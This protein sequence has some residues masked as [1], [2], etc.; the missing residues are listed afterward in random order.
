MRNLFTSLKLEGIIIFVSKKHWKVT[1][2]K[3]REIFSSKPFF[4]YFDSERGYQIK[5]FSE[6]ISDFEIST[7]KNFIGTLPKEIQLAELDPLFKN[8]NPGAV[9]RINAVSKTE[10]LVI[11]KH[12]SSSEFMI[13]L[14][15]VS[16]VF[17]DAIVYNDFFID[18]TNRINFSIQLFFIALSKASKTEI[19]EDLKRNFTHDSKNATF[20]KVDSV[21]YDFF[22]E[23]QTIELEPEIEL[24]VDNWLKI[25]E[26]FLKRNSSILLCNYIC[27]ILEIESFANSLLLTSMVILEKFKAERIAK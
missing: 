20:Q 25:S 27:Q 26:D 8:A 23:V 5:L 15:S 12:F 3:V 1:L 9:Q 21:L 17:T 11:P 10:S 22:L 13:F 19:L 14:S 7:L 24:W 16:N 18:E 4:F 2:L 6:N